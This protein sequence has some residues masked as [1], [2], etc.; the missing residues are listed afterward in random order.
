MDYFTVND[1]VFVKDTRGFYTF[2]FKWSVLKAA[3]ININL[4]EQEC[5]PCLC[6]IVSKTEADT[7]LTFGTH[8]QNVSFHYAFFNM[9]N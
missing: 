2:L 8:L 9:V 7:Q 6:I 4:D 1:L 5:P 3:I